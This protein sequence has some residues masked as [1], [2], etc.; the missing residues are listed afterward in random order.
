MKNA[1]RRLV[2]KWMPI[3]PQAVSEDIQENQ[4]SWIISGDFNSVLSSG[5]RLGSP[6]THQEGGNKKVYSKIDWAF[7]NMFWLQQFGH[8]EAEYLNHSISDHFPILIKC[9]QYNNIHPRPFRFFNNMMEHPNFAERWR[10]VWGDCVEENTMKHVEKPK[11]VKY[12]SKDINKYMASYKQNMHVLRKKLEII[13]G[14]IQIS[15]LDQ[16]LIDQEKQIIIELEKWCNIEEAALRQKARANWIEFGDSNSKYFHVQWKIRKKDCL[17]VQWVHSYYIKSGDM[18][19]LKIPRNA[20]WVVRKV[21][22]AREQMRIRCHSHGTITQQL[23]GVQLGRKFSI[24]KMYIS[25]LPK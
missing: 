12:Q 7:G 8:I 23:Q 17:C 3:K 22:E 13:Q 21:L 18:Y 11:N 19:Q 6:V 14:K 10:N 4:L 25:L 24:H 16:E 9:K 5:D 20:S 2:A 1:N 15:K